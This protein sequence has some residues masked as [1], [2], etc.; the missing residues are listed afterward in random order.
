MRTGKV[1]RLILVQHYNQM[2]KDWELSGMSKGDIALA[3]MGELSADSTENVLRE[4]MTIEQAVREWNWLW[5]EVATKIDKD[6][7]DHFL[8]YWASVLS[9]TNEVSE[10]TQNGL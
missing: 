5:N 6:Y 1:R 2:C 3:L 10:E 9:D 7:K 4:E 8:R